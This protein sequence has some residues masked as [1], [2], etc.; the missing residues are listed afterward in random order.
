MSES[1]APPPEIMDKHLPADRQTVQIDADCAERVS[2]TEFSPFSMFAPT[3]SIFDEA[4]TKSQKETQNVVLRLS[5]I[6]GLF[7]PIE[8]DRHAGGTDGTESGTRCRRLAAAAE[9][10][11]FQGNSALT[12]LSLM[13]FAL[14]Q[15]PEETAGK[16][17]M[18]IDRW[19]FWGVIIDYVLIDWCR[20]NNV[21]M[22][23]ARCD[24]RFSAREEWR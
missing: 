8:E 15:F 2:F 16:N 5:P 23:M 4:P 19:W 3:K 11:R 6:V 12:Q 20:V 7:W 18:E 13:I 17:L 21:W 10:H 14:A 22:G 9:H 1:P 24:W